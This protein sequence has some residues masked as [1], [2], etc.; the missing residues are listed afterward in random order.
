MIRRTLYEDT[1]TVIDLLDDVAG[2][3]W[4][5]V[6][7]YLGGIAARGAELPTQAINLDAIA[8]TILRSVLNDLDD[9]LGAD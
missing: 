6:K 4:V 2:G 1:D 7:L 5:Q 8:A 9:V 3:P